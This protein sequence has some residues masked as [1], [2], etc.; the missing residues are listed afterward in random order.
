MPLFQHRHYL[1]ICDRVLANEL[2]DRITLAEPDITVIGPRHLDAKRKRDAFWVYDLTSG[3]GG[4]IELAI[5]VTGTS[6]GAAAVEGEYWVLIDS[7]SFF[8]KKS[9]RLADDVRTRLLEFGA[10]E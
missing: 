8:S 5:S 4:K 1:L 6:S 2:V 10:T 3:D 7:A 9:S